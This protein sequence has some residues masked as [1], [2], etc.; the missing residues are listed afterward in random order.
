MVKIEA[1]VRFAIANKQIVLDDKNCTLYNGQKVACTNM[2]FC[3]KY[4]GLGI[5]GRIGEFH[6]QGVLF[7]AT[8]FFN[9]VGA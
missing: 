1:Y 8:Y 6:M 5:P 7:I 9:F 4:S 3:A 2:E